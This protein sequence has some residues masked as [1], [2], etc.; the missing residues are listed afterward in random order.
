MG[1]PALVSYGT[2][3]QKKMPGAGAVVLGLADGRL[4]VH[5][6]VDHVEQRLARL[7]VVERRMQV[8]GTEPAG[9]ADRIG[10]EGRDGRVLGE[11]GGEVGGRELPVVEL[12]GLERAGRCCG[13]RHVAPHHAIEV[14]V[15]AAG[16]A[17]GR[18]APRHVVRVARVDHLV[19]RLPLLL[20]ELER[21][22]ADRV[23]HLLVGRQ[24]GQ[25]GGHDERH[26]ARGLAERLQ[27][28]AERLLQLEHEALPVRGL[29][30]AGGGEHEL[31]ER[32]LLAPAD[33]RGN[34]VLRGHRRTVVEAEAV[35]QREAVLHGIAADR[36][37]VDHL[38]LDLQ[39]GVGGEERVPH[40]VGVVARE[41]GA[42]PDGVE[43]LEVADR[44][45][46]QRAAP[47]RRLR[48]RG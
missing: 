35:A 18:L 4:Q 5:L 16:R 33:Q 12:A 14:D 10:D 2:L 24:G 27:D 45:E 22:R 40:Q 28:Q 36:V 31:A 46:A 37:L 7:L 44:D 48:Q 47:P 43:D 1:A 9:E 21:S 34:A 38:R 19:A 11:P 26:V 32:I 15:L 17:A 42:R 29:Q 3:P 6:L 23:L 20:D 30:L 39:V 25:P 41:V 8:I 13:V